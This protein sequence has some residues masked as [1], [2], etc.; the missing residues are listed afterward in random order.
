M[1]SGLLRMIR[2]LVFVAVLGAVL[3]ALTAQPVA[4]APDT[5]SSES[6]EA[7]VSL[8]PVVLDGVVLFRVRGTTSYPAET[9]ARAIRRRIEG[10]ARDVGVRPDSIKTVETD[11]STNVMAGD[12]SIVS[13]FDADARVEGLGRHELGAAHLISVQHAIERYRRDRTP[14]VLARNAAK[15]G[16]ATVILIAVLWIGLRLSR[17]AERAI[18][19]RYKARI[20]GVTIRSFE[21]VQAERVWHTLI[22]AIRTVRVVAGLV[23]LF[24]YLEFV[25]DLFPWTRYVGVRLGGW[26]ID[27]F[28][29]LG[30]GAVGYLPNLFFLAILFVVTRYVL[31][32]ARLFFSG[33]ER[34]SVTISGF[35]T[36]WAQ[37]TY[38]IVRLL[39]VVFA[40]VV[41]YPYIPGAESPAFKG[42]S[43]FLGL[44]FSLGSSS[45]ISNILAGYTLTYRRAFKVGDRIQIEN[46]IGDVAAVRLQ[47]TVLS[48]VK[49]EE[50]IVP[51]SKILNTEIVNYSALAKARGLILHTTVGIGY[52]TPWRQVV[53]MLRMAA[54]RTPGLLKEPTPFVYQKSLGDFCVTY[55]LNAYCDN[56]QA[57]ASLYSEMHRNILDVFNEYG[58]QIMTPAYEGDPEQPKMVQRKDWYAAPAAPPKMNDEE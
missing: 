58:V 42:L 41:A 55:E 9:R 53:A 52:E 54:D 25:L 6:D 34:G 35:E 8:A 47:V 43:L 30:L 17:R 37:P 19:T 22:S 3:G 23:F 46:V 5:E 31:K 38:R 26:V 29:T 39:V 1:A 45:V 48:T 33:I 40:L 7:V 10:A 14:E 18:E 21:V 4:G 12:R 2:L 57:M 56:A 16:I 24:A 13:V 50:I 44:I 28:I 32:V 49:N 27:P 11:V 51:N 15:G 36:E 20:Q